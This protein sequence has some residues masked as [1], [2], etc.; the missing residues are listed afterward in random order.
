MQYIDYH[1]GFCQLSILF[2]LFSSIPLSVL[3]LFV[4]GASVAGIE[5]HKVQ[6]LIKN[7]KWNKKFT[8]LA[9]KS[10]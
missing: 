4:I 7:M 8:D 3:L 2:F 6:L 5:F 10:R 1:D 9:N